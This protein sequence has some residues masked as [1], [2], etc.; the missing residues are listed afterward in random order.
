MLFYD[1]AHSVG[2]TSVDSKHGLQI[3]TIYDAMDARCPS[4]ETEGHTRDDGVFVS[5]GVAAIVN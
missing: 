3:K 1:S 5:S 4:R 2:N